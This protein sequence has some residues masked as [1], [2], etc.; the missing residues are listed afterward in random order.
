V[1]KLNVAL[2]GTG[3]M[4]KAHALAYAAMPAYFWP[5]PAIPVRKVV[6]DLTE[7]LAATA[8]D[9]F[10]F[11]R[12]AT[13][14]RAVVSDSE[15]DI[16]DICTPN[17][18]HAEIAI[19]AANAGKHVMC[20]KPL[21]RTAPEARRMLDAVDA[22]RVTH[23]IAFNYRHT[24][25]VVF[26]R[27]LVAEGRIGR[28]L[29]F[30]GHYL[31]DWPAD[32][33]V[34]LSWRFQKAIAGSGTTGDIGSHV[35]DMA[36]HVVGEIESVNAVVR[37]YIHER[38]EPSRGIGQLA[39]A[40][41]NAAKRAVD[42]DDEVLTLL[43]FAGGVTG[44]IEATRNAWGRHNYLG[45]ELHGSGGSIVFNYER[46]DELQ[47]C[48]ADDPPA[49]RGFRTIYTGPDHPHGEALWPVAA[50][51]IG[52]LDIKVIE[53]HEFVQAIVDRRPAA[54]NFRD[55]YRIARICDALLESG[56]RQAW[57]EIAG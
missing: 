30:R 37:T 29:N 9:R 6:V 17:D 25:A 4:G 8:R 36:R 51:G 7:D 40:D 32:P 41:P 44:S 21:A 13:D 5:A 50:I 15:I 39:A 26:A 27:K 46:M 34:P 54:P 35:I 11:E 33:A 2:I 49:L 56:E 55:G 57:V 3:F 43:R 47:V 18:S 14:W 31:S 24:P 23:M 48:F 20:E 22:N 52:Y 53:C 16:V 42:V 19:A 1:R 10:G 45:F 12:S 38:P 28:L